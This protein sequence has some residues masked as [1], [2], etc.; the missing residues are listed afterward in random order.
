MEHVFSVGTLQELLN[1]PPG[2]GSTVCVLGHSRPGDGG[3]GLFHWQPESTSAPDHGLVIGRRADGRGRW[4]RV[5][6]EPINVRWFGARGDGADA[7]E[8]LQRALQAASEGGTVY[9]PSGSYHVSRPLAMHQGTTIQG[10]GLLTQLNYVGPAN[11]GCLCSATPQQS[12]AFHVTRLNLLIHTK[13]AWGI[14]L[15]G[16]SFGRFDHVTVHLRQPETAG[17]FGPADGQSPYY[18]LFTACHVAGPGDEQQNRCVAFLFA[19]DAAQRRLAANANQVIGG[20]INSCETAV[21]CEG[22]GN[23]F[24]GQVLEQC[25]Q[26]YVFDLPRGRYEDASQGT[27]NTISGCYTEYVQRVIVQRHASCVV[28]AEL[29][30][31]TGYESVFDG[32]DTSNSVVLTSHDGRLPASRSFMHRRVDLKTD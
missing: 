23:V 20:H 3:G 12:C 24:S 32:Q 25:K 1:T 27:V 16:M 19:A 7:T 30:H 4:H 28:T 9:L 6:S 26:G 13:K 14:D 22:T 17:F 18:N 29:T 11:T 10:D 31:T 5:V 15:R 21:V 2:A 8:A